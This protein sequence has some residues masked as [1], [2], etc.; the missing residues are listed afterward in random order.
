MLAYG[1]CIAVCL[2]GMAVGALS[3][4][5]GMMSDNPSQGDAAGKGG[6]I[7]VIV[8]F[9]IAIVISFLH[10]VKGIS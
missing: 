2:V 4:F 10:F 7:T 5:G 9:L 3:V 1:L 6:A 8:F